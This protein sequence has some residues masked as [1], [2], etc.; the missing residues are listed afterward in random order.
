MIRSISDTFCT[1]G[2]HK[3]DISVNKKQK[4]QLK[5]ATNKPERIRSCYQPKYVS[6]LFR[7]TILRYFTGRDRMSIDVYIH[8]QSVIITTNVYE[9]DSYSW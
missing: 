2:G 1:R 3:I 8:I 4:K 6:R 7:I 5:T 9:F